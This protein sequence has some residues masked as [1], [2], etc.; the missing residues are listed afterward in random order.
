MYMSKKEIV[1]RTATWPQALRVVQCPA[2][3]MT[4]ILSPATVRPFDN[5]YLKRNDFYTT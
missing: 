1:E 4:T 2:S 5:D 3:L